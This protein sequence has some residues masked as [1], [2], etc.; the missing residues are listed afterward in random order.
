MSNCIMYHTLFKWHITVHGLVSVACM[1]KEIF[2][3]IEPNHLLYEEV[4]FNSAMRGKAEQINN[5]NM[6]DEIII[7]GDYTPICFYC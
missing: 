5:K 1:R 6:K 3:A 7:I 2:H 4:F